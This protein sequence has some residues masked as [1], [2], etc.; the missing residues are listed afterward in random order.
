MLIFKLS[1]RDCRLLLSKRSVTRSPLLHCV[2]E[3]GIAFLQF[4]AHSEFTAINLDHL[5]VSVLAAQHGEI[6]NL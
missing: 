5:L 2:T 3:K 6:F 1:H 4:Q